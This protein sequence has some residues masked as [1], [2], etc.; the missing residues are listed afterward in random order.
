M[1]SDVFMLNSDAGRLA[2]TRYSAEDFARGLSLDRHDVLR[3]ELLTE[4]TLGM[5]KAMVDDFYGQLWFEAEGERCEI[6]LQATA[7]MNA[8]RRE[9]L[10]SVSST[11]RNAAAKGFMGML[12]D[13]LSGAMHSFGRSMNDYGREVARYGI[14]NP[15][16]VGSLAVDNMVP[17][18]TLQ[19]Y[20]NG[21]GEQ[22]NIDEDAG[23]AWNELEKSIVGKLADDVVVGVKGDR[24]EMV[25]IKDFGRR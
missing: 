16:E 23:E 12:K 21:L 8:D 15:A 5:V 25:I 18:W 7:D 13:V 14:V 10:L 11:G 17:I 6:H 20:R 3:L 4:E 2:A 22:R 1:K 9:E 24:I 19:T